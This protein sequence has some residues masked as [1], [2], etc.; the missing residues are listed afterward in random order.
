VWPTFEELRKDPFTASNGRHWLACD[1][2]LNIEYLKAMPF[3]HDL[4]LK[5]QVSLFGG[6]IYK[7]SLG[8]AINAC[9]FG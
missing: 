6:Y 1:V 4:D 9:S 7:E 3:F 8:S 2:L 5:D